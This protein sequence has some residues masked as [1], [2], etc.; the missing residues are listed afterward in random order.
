MHKASLF[1]TTNSSTV[2]IMAAH[3]RHLYDWEDYSAGNYLFVVTDY[4][5]SPGVRGNIVLIMTLFPN[6]TGDVA[7]SVMQSLMQDINAVDGVMVISVDTITGTA[8]DLVTVPDDQLG[9]NNVLGSRL[10]PDGIFRNNADDVVQ[11]YE[12]LLQDSRISK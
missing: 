2:A 10:I 1:S 4:E 8:N 12:E 11:L 7:D 3:K 6:A 9:T 5:A